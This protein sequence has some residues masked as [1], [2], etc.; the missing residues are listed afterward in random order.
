MGRAEEED[1]DSDRMNKAI[2]NLLSI[3]DQLKPAEEAIESGI[4]T[5]AEEVK[6]IRRR[7]AEA[8]AKS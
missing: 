1:M 5:L 3:K 7:I 4:Q 2:N 8:E 6:D